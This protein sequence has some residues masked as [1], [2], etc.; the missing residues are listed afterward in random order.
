MRQIT[1]TVYARPEPQGSS[2]AFV[3]A[4][5]ARIT[6][7]NTKL[8]PYRQELTH[9]AMSTLSDAGI[10]SPMAG[11]HIPVALTLDFFLA[12]PPSAP[13]KRKEIVVKPDIDK[14][15]RATI[16]SLTGIAYL[17]DAQ[18][19]EV[20]ARKHYGVPERVDIS[21]TVLEAATPAL[22][23]VDMNCLFSPGLDTQL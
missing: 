22:E 4:G 9:T 5:R 21:M 6:S 13:K 19:V 18:V 14:L 20:S 12:R 23:A 7:S 2:K 16:D 3:I 8:K 1:F 10:A 15:M 17:D 11:K